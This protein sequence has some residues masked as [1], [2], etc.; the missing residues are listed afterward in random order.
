MLHR[1]AMGVSSINNLFA[2]NDR[3]PRLFW[4]PRFLPRMRDPRPRCVL[5]VGDGF[6]QSFLHATGLAKDIRCTTEDLI[7]A[8]QHVQYL[9]T[10]GDPLSGPLWDSE[11]WPLLHKF[12]RDHGAPSGREFFRSLG[13]ELPINSTVREGGWTLITPS[14]AYE[15]RAYLWHFF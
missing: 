2:F 15:L 8:P 7:P 6:T 13:S 12:W 1:P 3:P 9:P 14:L 11:K 5:V 10:E 4:P